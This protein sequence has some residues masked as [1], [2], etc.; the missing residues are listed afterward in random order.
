MWP[1]YSKMLC[2]MSRDKFSRGLEVGSQWTLL[3]AGGLRR[4]LWSPADSAGFKSAVESAAEPPTSPPES[5]SG[6]EFATGLVR[7]GHSTGPPRSRSESAA[8]FKVRLES[9]G[10]RSESARI[11]LSPFGIHFG[12]APPDSARSPAAPRRIVPISLS[13]W[14]ERGFG[15]VFALCSET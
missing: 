2:C 13:L 1:Q 7:G 10:V 4:G 12:G 8:D 6:V 9:A 3:E 15:L 11:V 5:A 14:R